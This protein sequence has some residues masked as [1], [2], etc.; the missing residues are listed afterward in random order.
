MF[1]FRVILKYNRGD[2]VVWLCCLTAKG[3]WFDCNLGPYGAELP[4]W[5]QSL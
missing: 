4:C 2:T 1:L 3:C 5:S